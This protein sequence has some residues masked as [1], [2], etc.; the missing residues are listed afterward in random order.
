MRG[1]LLNS[2]DSNLSFQFTHKAVASRLRC[3]ENSP[4]LEVIF[5][6]SEVRCFSTLL[7]LYEITI[8]L[9]TKMKLKRLSGSLLILLLCRT[10]L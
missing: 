2:L 8:L 10:L 1:I 7:P 6:N 3:Q 5:N 4:Y 9:S